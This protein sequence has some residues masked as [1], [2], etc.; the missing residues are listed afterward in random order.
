MFVYITGQMGFY[1]ENCQHGS[2]K[3]NFLPLDKKEEG[4]DLSSSEIATRSIL[5]QS[6]N[7]IYEKE[8]LYWRQ[9]SKLPE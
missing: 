8:E 1:K 4:S 2:T 3:D 6:L 9:R 7:E 5:R